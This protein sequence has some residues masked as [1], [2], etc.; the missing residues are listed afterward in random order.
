M[1]KLISSIFV[2]LDKSIKDSKINSKNIFN[3]GKLVKKDVQYL[4]E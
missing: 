1:P 4:M 3:A 2:Q